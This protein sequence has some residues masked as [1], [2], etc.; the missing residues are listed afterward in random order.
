MRASASC[1]PVPL[2]RHLYSG[3]YTFLRELISNGSDGL[4]KICYASL[5]NP[6]ALDAERE[7]YTRIIVDK[8][9]RIRDI[10]IGMTK[11]DMVNNLGT[12]AKPGAKVG[13]SGIPTAES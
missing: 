10:D 13:F 1:R 3:K 8:V 6:L 11:A 12:I 7:L 5:T 2:F 9:L 4:D